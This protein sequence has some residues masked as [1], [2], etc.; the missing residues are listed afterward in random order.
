MIS[1]AI[2]YFLS[3]AAMMVLYFVPGFLTSLFFKKYSLL[4]KIALSFFFSTAWLIILVAVCHYAGFSASPYILVP[5]ALLVAVL[6]LAT[7]KHLPALKIERE[8]KVLLLLFAIIF[9][10]KITAQIFIKYYPAGS[11]YVG[12]YKT[13]LLFLQRDWT[14]PDTNLP[15]YTETYLPYRTPGFYM[16]LSFFLSIF[17]SSFWVCQVSATLVNTVFLFPTYLIAKQVFSKKIALLTVIFLAIIPF[18]ETSLYMHAKMLVAYFSFLM[19]YLF[20]TK[21]SSPYLIGA[22]A[23]LGIMIH[24]S[25]MIFI[26]ALAVPYLFDIIKKKSKQ[27]LL[28]AVKMVIAFAAVI[29]PWFLIT[30]LKYGTLASSGYN[31]FPIYTTNYGTTENKPEQLWEHFKKTSPLYIIGARVVNTVTFITPAILISKIIALFVPF[32]LNTGKT[33]PPVPI[34]FASNRDLPWAYHYYHSLPGILTML[35]F[36]FAM[37]GFAKLWK[38]NKKLFYFVLIPVVFTIIWYG[39]VVMAV[40][41][42]GVPEIV[43]ILVMVGFWAISKRKDREKLVKLVFILAIIELVVFSYFMYLH[44]QT[45]EE[46]A[47]ERRG[48]PDYAVDIDV[49]EGLFSAYKLFKVQEMGKWL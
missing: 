46:I 39:W 28:F 18:V 27:D 19:F 3:A 2:M 33:N 6:F 25:S 35:M 5:Y 44:I 9:V 48:N 36:V 11:D 12:H 8:I 31:N 40:L 34:N 21:K 4:E 17:G 14:L 32:T 47:I 41:R 42:S 23:G 22:V 38:R 10:A 29:A 24:Q 13:V 1:T 49:F 15:T 45:T 30:Y 20:I 26:L 7:R 37:I 43:P 16:L